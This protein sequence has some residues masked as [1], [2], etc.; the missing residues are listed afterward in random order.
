M[1]DLYF[2]D[3]EVFAEDWCFV[4][5]RQSDGHIESFWND[6]E[7]VQD[8]IDL[9]GPVLCGWN[10]RDY[11]AHILKAV[12]LGWEPSQVHHVSQTI[13]E[14]E[15]R[16][17]VWA[18]FSGSRWVDLPPIID[19]FHDVVPRK[20]L[21]EVE[22]NI[23][24][25]IVESSVPFDIDR[26]LTPE[27][28][29]EVE[30]YCLHDV[31]ATEA[32]YDLRFD[33]VKAK[34]DLCELQGV[35]PLTMLKHTNARVVSEVLRAERIGEHP[36]GERYECPSNL[37]VS[38]IPEQVL[39]FA[40][41]ITSANCEDDHAPVEFMFHDCPTTVG[42]GGIHAAVPSYKET[43]TDKRVVL[44]Q[45]I[46]SYYP[47]LIINNGY[48]SRAVPDASV[49]KQFYEMRMKAKTDGDK[50]TA[51]AA[52][53]VLNTTYGTMKD[54]YNKMY[55][56]MQATRVCLS[57]QL[58]IIDLIEQMYRAVPHGLQLIQLN[59]DGWVISVPRDRQAAILFAVTAWC[60]RTG[61]TVDT[62]FVETIVQANVNNYVM[63][64]V[65]GKVKA[66]GGVVARHAGGDFKS[67]SA[68]I[69][70][71][72]VVDYLLDGTPVAHTVNSCSDIERFQIVA[73]AGRT[74]QEVVHD[75]PI[76]CD[77]DT[78]VER[79]DVV[80]QRRNRVYATTDERYGG[81]F[82][83]KLDSEGKETGR[84]RVPLTPPHCFVDNE[85]LWHDTPIELTSLDKSW[86]VSLAQRKAREFI[87]RDKKERE[88]M[89]TTEEP[90]NELQKPDDNEV[91]STTAPTPRRRS[92]KT[93]EA[94]NEVNIEAV[95]VPTFGEKLF[96]LQALMNGAATGV[97]F[98]KVVAVGGGASSEYADTQQYK[99]WLAQACQQCGLLYKLDVTTQFLG[100]IGKTSSGGAIYA[101][102]A[103]GFVTLR[104]VNDFDAA[105][106]Y[107]VSGFG[108]NGQPG[109]CN[110]AA[111][112]NLLRNFLLN[113]IA[114]LD[115]KGREGD[116]Q[117]F[118][119]VVD[120]TKGYVSKEQKADIRQ[121]IKDEKA[122]EKQYATAL[123]AKALYD[124]IMQAR[125]YQP[126]FGDKQLAEHYDEDGSPKL[127]DDGK[128]T[129]AKLDAQRGLTKAEEIIAEG[130]KSKG[131][132]A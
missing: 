75:I 76:I 59:T 67:N 131:E 25:P 125:E 30:R 21:K 96:Q 55:D 7:G 43:A 5:K 108:S 22:A 120:N 73:K 29:A 35:D 70:D 119:G 31:E 57:G 6:C 54:Q 72:A 26:A 50:A 12:L 68:T 116:D 47:S 98:D 4:F 14:S 36:K 80:V 34:S 90:N 85:N 71:K 64:T 83:V 106:T 99:K 56:P 63:R 32:L 94:A 86:Y 104:D 107:A 102:Q 117:A 78:V 39:S 52:K 42:L 101:A 122:E 62:D 111:Q 24:L 113:G 33:Y 61:F 40:L 77:G 79:R 16:S 1:H 126:D 127:R 15:E 132:A 44:I 17:A 9:T 46:G 129:M 97:E 48:M 74:F 93:D 66:K 91:A 11:D 19:L 118:N 100:E 41:S 10:A 110:G 87:T 89:A 49:Y 130:E 58:Y 95:L 81:I 88:Q 105:E 38:A 28:R 121:G 92:K 2:F 20:S 65:D 103:D 115:N 51:E 8:F 18:L 23:C 3:S 114:L 123:F 37:D 124:T 45:D 13:V 82:K 109:F 112:T 69:I 27:E 128:S 53:L 84:S 60:E